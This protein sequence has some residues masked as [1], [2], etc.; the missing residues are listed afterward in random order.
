[1]FQVDPSDSQASKDLRPAPTAGLEGDVFDTP[2]QRSGALCVIEPSPQAADAVRVLDGRSDPDARMMKRYL[3]LPDLSRTPGSPVC[4]TI[5][6]ILQA[7][8]LA[9]F[10]QGVFP[11][12]V[13]TRENFDVL[14]VP[15]DHPARSTGDTYYLTPE[16]VLRTHTTTMWPYYMSRPETLAELQ[17]T[18]LV[19]AFAYG[20]CYRRDE[21]DRYHHAC[22]HQIDGLL[23]TE[24]ERQL[25]GLPELESVFKSIARSLYGPDVECEAREDSFPFTNPS[26]EL[27]VRFEDRMLEVVG[28]GIVRGEVLASFGIDP[29]RYNGWAFGFGVD[30][31]AMVKMQ[32]PDIRL[33]W[34]SDPRVTSQFT[35]WDSVYKPVT[36]FPTTFRDISFIAPKSFNPNL[37]FDL[38]RDRTAGPQGELVQEISQLDKFENAAKFGADRVSYTF[39]IVYASHERTLENAEVDEI[40]FGVREAVATQLPVEL[41]GPIRPGGSSTRTDIPAA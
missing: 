17:E 5:E 12:V 4:M 23:I 39:R 32:I 11:E 20:K 26:L 28:G 10:D 25:F 34:S 31:L 6:R 29:N 9:G 14:L 35:D 8:G 3:A 1:M 2:R 33:L 13:S 18:G 22:F 37:F 30:R 41:R 27:F 40:Q 21:V 36:R 15:P 16:M 19:R 24:K 7:E 38:V